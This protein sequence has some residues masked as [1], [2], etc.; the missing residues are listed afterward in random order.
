LKTRQLV[1]SDLDDFVA[2]YNAANRRIARR[3]SV[4]TP[5]HTTNLWLVIGR[6]WTSSG[7]VMSRWRTPIN[8]PPPEVI[9]AQI[10][11][12]LEAALAEFEVIATTLNATEK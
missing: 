9:A 5:S 4:F 12:D 2:C 10:V 11:E 6:R 1:R 8:L 7:Y 3:A